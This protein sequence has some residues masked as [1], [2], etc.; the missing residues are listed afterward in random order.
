[1]S[2][3]AGRTTDNPAQQPSHKVML[4]DAVLSLAEKRM[5]IKELIE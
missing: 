2:A 3:A 1:M 5:R 4:G